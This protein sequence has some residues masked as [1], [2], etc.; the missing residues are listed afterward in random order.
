MAEGVFQHMVDK[1][2][3]A[4][5]IVVDSAGTGSWHVGQKAHV[6]TRRELARHGI[7]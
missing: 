5:K 3:L 4:D 7:S 6:G 1:A 2:G